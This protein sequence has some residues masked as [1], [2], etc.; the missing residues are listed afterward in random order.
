MVR[1]FANR[2][3]I[4]GRV[5][6]K[7]Q[8][9]LLDASLLNTQ[10]YKTR[11][12]GGWIIPRKGLVHSSSPRCISLQSGLRLWSAN[13]FIYIYIYIVTHKYWIIVIFCYNSSL[14]LPFYLIFG[15]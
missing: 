3:S 12:M 4:T 13:L 10:N 6:P 9:M 1:V 2:V 15:Q 8:K 14:C 5:I 7:T 11:I